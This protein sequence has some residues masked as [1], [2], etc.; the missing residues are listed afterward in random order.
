MSTILT[1]KQPYIQSDPSVCVCL[2][3]F[4]AAAAGSA[5]DGGRKNPEVVQDGR[6]PD[7]LM[8]NGNTYVTLSSWSIDY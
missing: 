6:H 8:L 7:I 2:Q 3:V 4:A 5:G 1:L